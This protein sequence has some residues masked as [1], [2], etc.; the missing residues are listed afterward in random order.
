MSERLEEKFGAWELF[1][2]LWSKLCAELPGKG[3]KRTGKIDKQLE[4]Q[5]E[6]EW[7][8]AW[9]RDSM[10]LGEDTKSEEKANAARAKGNSYFH[11]KV[12]R[13]IEAVKQYN[14]SLCYSEPASEARAIAYANRSA[15]CYDLHRYE[16]CLENIRLARVANYPE[17]LAD[18]LAKREQ[19]AKQALADK[20][21]GGGDSTKPQQIR[22]LTLT[23]EANGKV[24][25]VAN[26]LELAESKQF[27]RYVITNRDLKA[28]DIVAHEQ[29]THTILVDTYRH[30]RCDYC[31]Q[32]RLY[33]LLPCEGCTVAMY[34]SDECRTRAQLT[35]HR[36][37]CPIIR[38]MWRIFTKIPVMALRTVT[39][40]ITF[41]DHNLDEMLEHLDTLNEATVN[42][43][44]MDWTAATKRDIYNTVHVLATNE[45]V[46]DCK[47]MGQRIFFALIIRQL[48]LDRTPLGAMCTGD[49]KK[50]QLL[51]DLLR[52]HLQ[53]TPTNM[54]SLY[55]MK[56]Q[57][58]P[59]NFEPA[60]F[61]SACFPV[62]SMINH[63]CAPNMTRVTL[64]DRSCGVLIIRPIAKG[65][66]LFD[67]YGNHHCLQDRATRRTELMRQY[68]FQCNCEACSNNYAILH[69]LPSVDPRRYGMIDSTR[70]YDDLE[71]HEMK[72]A[73]EWYPQLL[74]YI[75]HLGYQY[76]R[77]ELSS[78]QELF[79]RAF[80]IQYKES[81]SLEDFAFC[82]P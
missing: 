8:T 49:P 75:N 5:L 7:D 47:D 24:P 82:N 63:S 42:P 15:V 74:K 4:E 55:Y 52:R 22:S 66:Q 34:C 50:T 64:P 54:H 41:F 26:C 18:K 3:E 13:Y 67:N 51:Y 40:A 1:D 21:T 6:Q 59:N 73:E 25:Q 69:R 45:R 30:M 31:L 80:E 14:E 12:K 77:Y 19:A 20:A 36:Y 46:R 62:L 53:T 17:R 71:R 44:A 33:T 57:I 78:A 43:F 35:Y 38:D 32:E 60:I 16:E 29:P 65:G 23:Y 76:P 79:L 2:A 27:G 9:V 28:G 58:K 39:M 68:R 56:Y 11:P 72:L 48:L 81:E 10:K 61:A 37:E 70:I